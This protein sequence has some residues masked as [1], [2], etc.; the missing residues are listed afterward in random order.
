MQLL[1]SAFGHWVLT[2]AATENREVNFAN[3]LNPSSI[4]S[5]SPLSLSSSPLAIQPIF[6]FCTLCPRFIFSFINISQTGYWVPDTFLSMLV[7][8]Y[9]NIFNLQHIIGIEEK[10]H[11]ELRILHTLGFAIL[12]QRDYLRGA[13][14]LS[15][16]WSSRKVTRSPKTPYSDLIRNKGKYT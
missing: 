1:S 13:R 10:S 7:G 11:L 12:E 6:P 15:H 9:L 3:R 5:L 14:R 4:P 2:K 16:D 8:M